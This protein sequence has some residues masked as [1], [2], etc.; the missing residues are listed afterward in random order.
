MNN[1]LTLALALA[2]LFP[3]IVCG[4]ADESATENP[5]MPAFYVEYLVVQ[6]NAFGGEGA[7]KEL[8]ELAEISRSSADFIAEFWR[9]RALME[10]RG[11]LDTVIENIFKRNMEMSEDELQRLAQKK[12]SFLIY[13]S[14]YDHW[15]E[16][17]EM[18][19]T[20]LRAAIE[21]EQGSDGNP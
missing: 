5:G 2:L 19:R 3:Q 20:S 11:E 14:Y 1:S 18:I 21:G 9:A 4:T 12:T 13:S 7:F 17:N 10:V 6:K 15:D 16:I 8:M